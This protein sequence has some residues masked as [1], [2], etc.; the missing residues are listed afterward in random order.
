M[1]RVL[2]KFSHIFASEWDG[3][4]ASPPGRSRR[5]MSFAAGPSGLKQF[6][7]FLEMTGIPGL[8]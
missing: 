2:K 8:R 3:W 1:S 4:F 5:Q 6:A 7:D